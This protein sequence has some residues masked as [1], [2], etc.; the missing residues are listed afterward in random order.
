[1]SA[2]AKGHFST[3]SD[4]PSSECTSNATFNSVKLLRACSMF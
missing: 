4:R 1:L 3:G 2:L